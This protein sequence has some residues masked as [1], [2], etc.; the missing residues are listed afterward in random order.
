MSS[1]T[2]FVTLYVKAKFLR[3]WMALI[4]LKIGQNADC[5]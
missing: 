2:N 3:V 5:K 4:N 1:A